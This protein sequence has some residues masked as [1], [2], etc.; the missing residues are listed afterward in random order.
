MVIGKSG[1]GLGVART[2][3]SEIITLRDTFPFHNT[4]LAGII[5]RFSYKDFY[6]KGITS[7]SVLKISIDHNENDGSMYISP[8]GIAGIK[9]KQLKKDAK[10][11][12]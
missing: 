4:P 5:V 11:I 10:N 12:H 8:A 3:L 2:L 7:L 1:R 6:F 9:P